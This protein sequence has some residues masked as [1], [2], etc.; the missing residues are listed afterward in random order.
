M[1]ALIGIVALIALP[2]SSHLW[3]N[4][5][6]KADTRQMAWV[7]R[8]ARQEA[9]SQGTPQAVYFYTE[10]GFYQYR[11]KIYQLSSGIRF[12]G[13][14][15]FKRQYSTGPRTCIFSASGAPA[16]A[17]T[18]VLGNRTGNKLYVI[19]NVVAGRVRISTNPPESWE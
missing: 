14:T 15:T 11:D 1:L 16:Q 13:A 18:A 8:L 5:K 19:V 4:A 9:V 12:V 7:L 17:G 3:E 10:A 6:L 2:A